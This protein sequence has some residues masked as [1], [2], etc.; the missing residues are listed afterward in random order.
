MIMA[1]HFRGNLRFLKDPKD[2][3]I[4]L[5][6]VFRVGQG[7]GTDVKA[8]WLAMSSEAGQN[9]M[10]MLEV[11]ANLKNGLAGAVWFAGWEEGVRFKKHPADNLVDHPWIS[12]SGNPPNFD[13]EVLSDAHCP[14]YF[15]PRGVLPVAK[16]CEVIEEYCESLGDR[17][18]GINWVPGELNGSRPS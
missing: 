18:R 4:S 3:S 9:P 10:S 12:D 7:L 8:S 13:P 17:P 16:I 5:E 1:L 6:D 2:V 11:S 14:S 15:D